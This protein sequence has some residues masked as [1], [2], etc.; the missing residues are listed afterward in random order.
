MIGIS[1]YASQ[2]FHCMLV[3]CGDFKNKNSGLKQN[4]CA[5]GWARISAKAGSK[6]PVFLVSGFV[7]SGYINLT[8]STGMFGRAGN[9]GHW[10]V[11]YSY[12]TTTHAYILY[13]NTAVDPFNTGNRYLGFPLRCLST[14]LDM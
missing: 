3:E 9:S 12:S 14:V 11:S 4:Y 1:W 8:L 13:V 7:R 6:G 10:W 5:P 2:G